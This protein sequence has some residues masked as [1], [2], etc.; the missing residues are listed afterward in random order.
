MSVQDTSAISDGLS[1]LRRRTLP[2]FIVICVF[3]VVAAYTAPLNAQPPRTARAAARDTSEYNLHAGVGI[4]DITPT[5]SVVLAGSPTLLKSSSVHTRLYAKA[6]V[7]SSGAQKVAIVTL[8]TL[9]YP[10]DCVVQARRQIEKTSDIPADKVMICAFTRTAARYG[11][12][13]KTGW[14][15]PLPKRSRLPCAT[16]RRAGSEPLRARPRA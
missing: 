1:I 16:S 13:T 8:D 14:Q 3:A 2:T 7:L 11:L 4:V 6:L 9:K 10:L 15:P 12:I 5:E